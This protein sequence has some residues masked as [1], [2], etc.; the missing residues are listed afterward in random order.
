MK[1]CYLNP[2]T[3]IE[4]KEIKNNVYEVSFRENIEEKNG[5]YFCDEYK[6]TLSS[7]DIEEDIKTKRDSLLAGAKLQDEL[8]KKEELIKTY[9]NSLNNTDY[10]VIKS[11]EY[12]SLGLPLDLDYGKLLSDRQNYRDTINNLNSEISD[13]EELAQIK[14]RKIK[15]LC[16]LNQTTIINGID[17][18]NKHYRLNTTDQI[19]LTSL[20]SLAQ[21]GQSVPYHA[22]GELCEIFPAEKMINLVQ[23]AI[24]FIIYHTTYFNLLK[25]QV[26]DMTDKEEI[27]AV[28]YGDELKDEYKQILSSI[29]N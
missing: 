14:N 9:Q 29:T 12:F 19:N 4:Y 8:E 18:E 1:L 21:L 25:H 11:L 24:K 22:D 10:K 23:T 28:S 5:V 2:I 26:L 27:E 17:F 15:E 16:S 13:D 3:S 6:I 20:Y 7:N